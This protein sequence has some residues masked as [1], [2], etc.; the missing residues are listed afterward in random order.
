MQ[1]FKVSKHVKAQIIFVM[2]IG[3]TWRAWCDFVVFQLNPR[4]S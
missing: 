1:I 3:L 2:Q 4:S